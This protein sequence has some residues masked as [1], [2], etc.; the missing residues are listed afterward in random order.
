[1]QGQKCVHQWRTERKKGVPANQKADSSVSDF[2]QPSWLWNKCQRRMAEDEDT[3]RPHIHT[4]THSTSSERQRVAT[5]HTNTL[6]QYR[7]LFS[8]IEQSFNT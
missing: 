1:M 4:G 7:G 5:R 2:P 8:G 6:K 3:T